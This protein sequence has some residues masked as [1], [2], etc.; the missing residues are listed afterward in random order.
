MT[1]NPNAEIRS[2]NVSAAGRGGGGFSPRGGRGGLKHKI[3]TKR[4]KNK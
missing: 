3:K 1:F 2:D 4:Q